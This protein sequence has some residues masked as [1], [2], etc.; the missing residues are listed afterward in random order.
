MV[1]L[2]CLLSVEASHFMS[3]AAVAV[4]GVCIEV[5]FDAEKLI[6]LRY[7]FASCRSAGLDLAS[8][9]SD[10]DVCDASQE[11]IWDQKYLSIGF[12]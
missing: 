11:Y 8:V 4:D 7:A 9:Q 3:E 2:A 5:F 10:G 1:L 6:V 12:L